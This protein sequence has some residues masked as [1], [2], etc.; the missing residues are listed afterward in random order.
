MTINVCVF[1]TLKNKFVI[2]GVGFVYKAP[3]L[4]VV[5]LPA[6]MDNA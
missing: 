5:K 4:I 3:K 1:S 6:A 2:K